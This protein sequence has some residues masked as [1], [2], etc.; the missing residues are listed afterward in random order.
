MPLRDYD[1]GAGRGKKACVFGRGECGMSN[2]ASSFAWMFGGF[3]VCL[4]IQAMDKIDPPMISLVILALHAFSR[5]L[6]YLS[7]ESE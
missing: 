2:G 1:G 3:V 5:G 6:I 7:K 4:F